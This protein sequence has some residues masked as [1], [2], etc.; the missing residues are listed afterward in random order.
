[1]TGWIRS[2]VLPTLT[3]F[4]SL[5]TLVCCAL[6]ALFVTLGA[7]ATLAGLVS[8]LPQLIWFSENKIPLFIFSAIM[9]GIGG[10]MQYRAR[11][12]P[13]P[14]DPVL[15]RACTRNRRISLWVYGISLLLFLVGLFFAFLAER[16]L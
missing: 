7:G 3:L 12:E 14:L 10:V 5:S 13:C 16:I 6:P 2:H 1:M 8:S 4:T 11:F 15:A 9:L